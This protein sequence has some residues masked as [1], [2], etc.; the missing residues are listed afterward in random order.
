MLLDPPEALAPRLLA[1][2]QAWQNAQ[3]IQPPNP[4]FVALTLKRLNKTLDL[5]SVEL[6]RPATPRPTVVPQEDGTLK[7]EYPAP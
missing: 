3:Q 2:H 7:L 1:D 6:G 5:C 4:S